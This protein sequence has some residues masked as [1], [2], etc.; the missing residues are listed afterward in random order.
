MSKDGINQ[1]YFK[2]RLRALSPIRG[3]SM[4][5]L[6]KIVLVAVLL[7]GLISLSSYNSIANATTT[8]NHVITGDRQKYRIFEGACVTYCFLS[9]QR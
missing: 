6:T 8:T 1:N 7:S 2:V 4:L 3:G 5:F 9:K